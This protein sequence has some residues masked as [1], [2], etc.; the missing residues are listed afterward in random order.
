MRKTAL[1]AASLALALAL[2]G[3]KA[4]KPAPT[5]TGFVLKDVS[6]A[7]FSLYEQKG[8][9]V[10]IEFWAT[11]CPPCK[12]AVP[13][14]NELNDRLKGKNAVL[15]TISI[16]ESADDVK[17]FVKEY[18]INYTVLIDDGT[19]NEKFRVTNIPTTVILDKEGKVVTKHMGF[20]PGLGE[21]FYKEIEALL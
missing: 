9:V 8:K 4:D 18:G 7:E 12:Q 2:I 10:M 11:W 19:V 15:V 6:G 20:T 3:C 14:L 16:D 1:L 21:F 17:E 5:P 13:E